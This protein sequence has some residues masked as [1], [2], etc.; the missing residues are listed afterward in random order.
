MNER[1]RPFISKGWVGIEGLPE[2][3]V[4]ILRDTGAN[5]SLILRGLIGNDRLLAGS[6]RIKVHGLLSKS[7]MPMCAVQLKSDYLSAE[8]MLGVCPDIPVPGVQVILGNDLCG[9]KVLRRVMAE[10]VPEECP[11]GHGMGGTPESVNL[12]DIRGDESGD[13]QAIQYLVSVVMKAEVADEEDAGEDEMV[14]IQPVEDIVVDIAW[15]FEEGPAQ[16]DE[17]SVR[18]EVKMPQPKKNTVKRA[19][20]SRAQPAEIKSWKVNTTC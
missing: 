7:D 13:R 6:R 20:L 4:S 8:V 10:T 17:V 2:V 14:S 18:P 12:T 15:L 1:Y 19:D 9:T 16:E 5:Q 11:E 3:E